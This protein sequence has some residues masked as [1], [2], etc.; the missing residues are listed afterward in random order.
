MVLRI[1]ALAGEHLRTMPAPIANA[2]L[3]D[4]TKWTYVPD[5]EPGQPGEDRKKM[6][7]T[8]GVR[9]TWQATPRNKIGFSTDPQSRYWQSASANQAPE[10]FS[11]WSFQHE[12]FTTVTYSSPVTNKLLLDA[13]FGH[14][15]EGFVD[16]CAASVNP[17]CAGQGPRRG[18]SIRLRCSRTAQRLQIPRE[19]LLLLSV[20]IYGTQD[21][22]HIMQAQASLSYVTGAHAMK[23]GWQNDFGTST[24]LQLRQHAGPLLQVRYTDKRMGPRRTSIPRTVAGP[25]QFGAARDAVLRD[26]ASLSG[27]GH[28]RP[29][30]VDDRARHDQWRPPVRLLQEQLPRSASRADGLDADAE[31]H[32]SRARTTPT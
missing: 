13:R 19:W 5:L 26:D 6:T 22:P 14:H 4:P 29:G 15:A 32:H 9:I 16:D 11:S 17:A 30:Q 27:N 23:F 3:G 24:Q 18:W 1:D 20:A 12:T 10:V 21:A 31:P 28:L 2:N 25:G 8:G 7:P